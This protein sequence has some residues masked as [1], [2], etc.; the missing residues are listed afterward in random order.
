MG[1][2]PDAAKKEAK[3][4]RQETKQNKATKKLAKKDAKDAGEEDIEKI[5]AEI[6]AKEVEKTAVT[7]T[8]CPPPSPRANFSLTALPSG[9]LIMFGGEYYDGEDTS[10]YN[11]LFRWNVDRCEWRKIE[12]PNTPPPRCSHQAV[13][14]RD[15]IYVFGGEFTTTEQFYHHRDLWRLHIKTNTWENLEL[16]GRFP[17]ARSGHRM[18]V[19][20]N[21]LVLFGGFYEAAREV[22]WYGDLYV[23]NFQDLKWRKIEFSPLAVQPAPRSGHQIAV[24]ENSGQL[25]LYG[26]YSKVKNV[27]AKSEGKVH[28][29]MFVLNLMPLVTGASPVWDKIGKKGIPPSTRSGASMIIHKSRALVFGGVSDIEGGQ[30][31]IESKFFSDLYAF[32]MDRR[33][34]YRLMLKAKKEGGRRGKKVSA[35]E[36]SDHSDNDDENTAKRDAPAE[37][38]V[39]DY[40]DSGDELEQEGANTYNDNTFVYIDGQGKLV[41]VVET[42]TEDLSEGNLTAELDNLHLQE[43]AQVEE[44]K[45]NSAESSEKILAQEIE[46]ASQ[47]SEPRTEEGMESSK[48]YKAGTGA[49]KISEPV[50]VAAAPLPRINCGLAMR[51]NTLYVYGGLLEV[52]DREFTLDDCWALDLNS[53]KEWRCILPGTM[54]EQEWKDNDDSEMDSSGDEDSEDEYKERADDQYDNE[55][56]EE[57]KSGDL[58][59]S[60]EGKTTEEAKKKK[61]DRRRDNIREEMR[62]LQEQ[63]GT[64]DIDRTPQAGEAL[65]DFY[66]R[67]NIYWSTEFLKLAAERRAAEE[68][69]NSSGTVI[70]QRFSEKE[71]RRDAFSLAESRYSEIE[72]VLTRLNEL[73]AEQRAMELRAQEAKKGAKGDRKSR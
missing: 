12:S 63:L 5:L 39:D 54:S 56:C 25:F 31:I 14:Y 7:I 50:N 6:M 64:D 61:K 2:K 19:W 13:V 32:D 57:Q 68:A 29:D 20:R 18:A 59:A 70:T 69:E 62:E 60:E 27:G 42:E 45:E 11:D 65:R 43:G 24:L 33:R 30:H 73:E 66:K 22:K 49:K 15:H 48:V 34:W 46:P 26:G 72:P 52:K 51:G 17:T 16:Q 53:R 47:K 35:E 8:L 37:V 55:G 10:C 41:Y 21:F 71:L 58:G 40:I 44:T 67:T 4:L 1:K 36:G 28:T 23:M 9:E 38:E 3:K